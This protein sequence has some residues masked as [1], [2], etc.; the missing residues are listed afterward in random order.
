MKKKLQKKPKAEKKDRPRDEGN[1]EADE[2]KVAITRK[3]KKDA[4]EDKKDNYEKRPSKKL[5]HKRSTS[6]GYMPR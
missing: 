6:D 1:Q 5:A 4:I 2:T 3:G